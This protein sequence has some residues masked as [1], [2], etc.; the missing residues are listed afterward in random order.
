MIAIYRAVVRKIRNV[1]VNLVSEAHLLLIMIILV[2]G[3]A[4]S[5]ISRGK[6]GKK[7]DT[8]WIS[9]TIIV[10]WSLRKRLVQSR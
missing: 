10:G 1:R 6:Q 8:G 9:A 7:E 3:R 4:T 5:N 2:L